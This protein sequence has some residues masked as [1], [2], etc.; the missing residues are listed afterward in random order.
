MKKVEVIRAHG[1][2]PGAALD[3]VRALSDSVSKEFNLKVTP[4]EQGVEFSGKNVSYYGTAVV[5]DSVVKVSLDLNMP[6]SLF[7]KKIESTI[8]ERMDVLLLDAQAEASVGPTSPWRG[9]ARST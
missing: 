3:L 9:Y 5:E 7:A 8:I 1:L 4:I 6:A 2:T